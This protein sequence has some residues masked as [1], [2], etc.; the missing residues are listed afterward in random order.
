MDALKVG[1]V[2]LGV[3]GL[4][5]ARNVLKAGH[6]VAGYSRSPGPGQALAVDGA[7]AAATAAQAADGAGIAVLMVPGPEEVEAVLFDADGVVAG[8][9]AGG[10][11]A[12]DEHDRSGDG[13]AS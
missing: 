2:G 13:T 11:G 1:F 4:P 7:T 12:G 9:P 5:M 10:P 8:M 6:A 3:M